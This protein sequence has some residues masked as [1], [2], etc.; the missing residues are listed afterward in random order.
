MAS[1]NLSVSGYTS[2]ITA[3][4][5]VTENTT[6]GT[7]RS[8][9]LKL[10]V[11]AKDTT[12]ARDGYY[13]V[14]C[15]ESGTSI[16]SQSYVCPGSGSTA[17]TLFE[18]TFNVTMNSD[19]TTATIDFSFSANI[20]SSSVG[21]YRTITGTITKLTLT[22]TTFTLTISEGTGTSI[23]VKRSGTRIY[24][25]ATL[26]SGDVLTITFSA[27]TGYTLKTHTVAGTT[28]T[29][30]GTYTVSKNTTVKATATLNSY[31]LTVSTDDNISVTV[32]DEL[33]G[34][35]Y[36]NGDYIS[37]FTT[38]TISFTTSNGYEVDT[39]TVNGTS[40]TD[41]VSLD[42][43]SAI[44]VIATSKALGLVYIN[45]GS[46]FEAYQVY[47]YN[48]SSWDLYCPYVYNGSSWDMCA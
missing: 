31:L 39:L 18:E 43:S 7:T 1:H 25:G 45:T 8:V 3:T 47:I 21:A 46:G 40:Y 16:S 9:T 38:I 37:H 13:S 32:Y 15:E 6:T 44:T 27:N 29:S 33:S 42:V 2:V 4:A 19:N 14:S 5:T 10:T 36:V 28:F 20:Y 23:V 48:G 24:N 17:V 30:G 11:K 34:D 22:E 41:G 12:Y 35:Y 26:Y